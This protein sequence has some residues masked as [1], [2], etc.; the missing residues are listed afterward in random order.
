MGENRDAARRAR[1]HDTPLDELRQGTP[2]SRGETPATLR[3]EAATYW[4]LNVAALVFLVVYTF[5]SIGEYTTGTW[6][7]V[8]SLL[9]IACYVAF[10]VD[11][12]VRLARSSPRGRWFRHHLFDLAVLLVPTLRPVRLLGAFT[13]MASFRRSAGSS[14]R[15]QMIIYGI[16]TALLLIWQAS[17]LVLEVERHAPGGNIRTFGDAIW[18]AFCTVTTVGYGDYTPVTAPGRVVA[19]GLMIGGVVLVGLITATFSSWVIERVTRGHEDQRP[20]TRG[21]VHEVLQA[22]E[23]GRATASAPP[24]PP[25]HPAR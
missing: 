15:A 5:R 23:A 2:A 16:G 24:S 11:Y 19:V 12:L 4:P 7:L 21:D 13:R 20:A 25:P 10:V 3:W 18:W 14:L 22:V 9:I 8:T 1:A 6:G 17:L